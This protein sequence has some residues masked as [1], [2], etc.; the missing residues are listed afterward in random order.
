ML[1]QLTFICWW[2]VYKLVCYYNKLESEQWIKNKGTC[3]LPTLSPRTCSWV[4]VGASLGSDGKTQASS[5]FLPSGASTVLNM[6][7][8][9]FTIRPKKGNSMEN[10]MRVS[11]EESW[12]GMHN[13]N[14]QSIGWKSFIRYVNYM[15]IRLLF[16]KIQKESVGCMSL[17]KQREQFK[18][19]EGIN[20]TAHCK[21][22][23]E[24]EA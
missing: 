20:C 21:E 12:N 14:S 8:Y 18:K 16:L 4:A 10:S 2:R 9:L 22:I 13:F 6:V 17:W 7:A 24:D 1:A 15:S 19:R 5:F 3:F 23:E 11:M